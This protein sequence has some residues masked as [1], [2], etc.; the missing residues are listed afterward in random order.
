[1]Q[2]RVTDA[3]SRDSPFHCSENPE[4]I[5]EV[6]S[7]I[8]QVR[9][10][11]SKKAFCCRHLLLFWQV[12]IRLNLPI[13]L[14]LL[15][16]V[17]LIPLKIIENIIKLYPI[18]EILAKLHKGKPSGNMSHKSLVLF[19]VLNFIEVLLNPL[20]HFLERVWVQF[21]L[22]DLSCVLANQNIYKLSI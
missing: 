22:F 13:G 14:H 11:S 16:G 8:E 21:V 7:L 2:S 6:T 9:Q 3:I 19:R 17:L 4:F 5:Q 20:G 10:A 12:L 15:D 1:M 18:Y